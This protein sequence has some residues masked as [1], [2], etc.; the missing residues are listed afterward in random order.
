[1]DIFYK[2]TKVVGRDRGGGVLTTVIFLL[3]IFCVPYPIYNKPCVAYS[4]PMKM[5]F[6]K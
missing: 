4:L 6:Q 2:K 1:M 3:F 5:H